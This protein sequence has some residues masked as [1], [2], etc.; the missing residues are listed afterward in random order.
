MRTVYLCVSIFLHKRVLFLTLGFHINVQHTFINFQHF[1]HK[2]AFIWNHVFITF[3]NSKSNLCLFRD[4]V[5]SLRFW[6]IKRNLIAIF[7]TQY[8]YIDPCVYWVFFQIFRPVC[9]FRPVRLFGTLKYLWS[10]SMFGTNTF[11]R[12]LDSIGSK[13]AACVLLVLL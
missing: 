4:L 11:I 6:V 9:L 3:S 10:C 13:S 8:V 7:P 2:H 5:F 12:R 1:S